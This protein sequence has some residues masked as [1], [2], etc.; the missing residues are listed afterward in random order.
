MN[1]EEFDMLTEDQKYGLVCQALEVLE[2]KESN[3]EIYNSEVSRT[4]YLRCK[5]TYEFQSIEFDWDFDFGDEEDL[6]KMFDM[7]VTLLHF[8]QDVAPDQSKPV[9][10]EK[11]DKPFKK[12]DLLASAKQLALLDKLGVI[13]PT[14]CSKS[15]ASKLIEEA[16]SK[17]GLFKE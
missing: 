2:D 9:K 15:V 17:N 5:P 13:Y 8:L 4:V 7:Y 16:K 10:R 6:N 3:K 14:N 12:E 11:F 1:K